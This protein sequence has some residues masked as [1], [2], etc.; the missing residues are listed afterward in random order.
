MY[1]FL[2]CFETEFPIKRVK[3]KEIRNNRWLS[4]GLIVSSK[5]MEILNNLKRKFTLT[6]KALEYTKNI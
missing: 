3:L 5:R 1:I 6:G 2:L 4:V